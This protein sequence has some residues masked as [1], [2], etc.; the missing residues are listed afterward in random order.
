M[1]SFSCLLYLYTFFLTV[2][3]MFLEQFSMFFFIFQT[4]SR[5]QTHWVESISIQYIWFII[6]SC[7][8]YSSF[9]CRILSKRFYFCCVFFW[10]EHKTV[11]QFFLGPHFTPLGTFE[12]FNITIL[13]SNPFIFYVTNVNVAAFHGKIH[14]EN[15]YSYV[16]QR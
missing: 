2:F 7:S 8:S 16:G 12:N 1:S 6:T 5:F 4:H 3:H 10:K 9:S 13:N 11:Y 15:I 14:L